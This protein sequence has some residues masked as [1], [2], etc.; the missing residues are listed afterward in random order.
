MWLFY[1]AFKF[2]LDKIWILK[3]ILFGCLD[4][5]LIEY[6][7]MAQE[8]ATTPKNTET[9]PGLKVKEM[10]R[11]SCFEETLWPLWFYLYKFAICYES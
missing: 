7:T 10:L 9:N 3:L 2:T 1:F 4:N 11:G 8:P 6:S 5:M